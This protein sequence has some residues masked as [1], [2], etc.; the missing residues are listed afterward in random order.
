MNLSDLESELL[1]F[2]GANVEFRYVARYHSVAR[3]ISNSNRVVL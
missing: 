1:F 3:V 2:N